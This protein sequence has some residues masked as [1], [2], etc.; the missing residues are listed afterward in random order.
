[1][2][3]APTTPAEQ[4]QPAL[5]A[6]PAAPTQPFVRRMVLTSV[7]QVLVLVNRNPI[8]AEQM[9]R[10]AGLANKPLSTAPKKSCNCGA[11]QN[12]TTPDA[13]KQLAENLLSSLTREDFLQMKSILELDELCYY[14]RTA[15]Q[16]KLELIC[17]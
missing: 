16:N 4:T 10:F 12:I 5:T 11:K 14:T 15:N 17:V 3:D 8:L 9:P 7:N 2:S 13:T 1:M 6:T